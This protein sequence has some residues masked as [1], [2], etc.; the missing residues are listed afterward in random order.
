MAKR[1][2]PDPLIEALENGQTYTIT[3]ADGGDLA[4]MRAVLKHGQTLTFAPVQDYGRVQVDDIVIVKWRGGGYIMHLVGE[5]QGD[6]FLI[7]NSLG[8]ENGW[9]HG[10]DILGRVTEII[11]PEPQPPVPQMLAELEEAYTAVI[12]EVNLTSDDAA[13]LLSVAADMRWYADIIGAEQWDELPQLNQWSFSQH[14]W[15]VMKEAK[16]AAD[17]PTATFAYRLIHHGKE[18]VGFIASSLELPEIE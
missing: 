6:R 9:T 15:H 10:R 3:M 12:T 8:K 11:D 14:L 18:H 2:S 13:R 16:R 4:S 1:K 7:I 5:R 17:L